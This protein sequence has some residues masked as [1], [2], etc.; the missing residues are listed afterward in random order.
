M[1]AKVAKNVGI[2]TRY[3]QNNSGLSILTLERK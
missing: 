1:H 3:I 2:K